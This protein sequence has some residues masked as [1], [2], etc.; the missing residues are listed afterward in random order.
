MNLSLLPERLLPEASGGDPVY[1]QEGGA[2][3]VK[4]YIASVLHWAEQGLRL[5]QL[6]QFPIQ[7][8]TRL[9]VQ[10]APRARLAIRL[11][12]P[13]WCWQATVKLNGRRHSQ[14]RQ[15]GGFIEIERRWRRGD[16]I[17]LQLPRTKEPPP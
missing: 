16:E 9:L 3:V 17:V 1:F 2:L 4:R 10:E 5:R 7:D 8:S 11:H 14:S 6:T 12:H 13:S 15:P